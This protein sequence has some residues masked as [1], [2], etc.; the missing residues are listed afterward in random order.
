[1]DNVYP[2]DIAGRINGFLLNESSRPTIQT[3]E[4]IILESQSRVRGYLRGKGILGLVEADDDA[5]LIAR[6]AV[7]HIAVSQVEMARNRGP[8]EYAEKAWDRAREILDQIHHYPATIGRPDKANM[9]NHGAK[10]RRNRFSCRRSLLD[11]MID[12][13]DV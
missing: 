11:R 5:N 8:S 6:S 9:P 4:D 12:Y 13:G 3:V 10:A 1:M 2:D 7:I